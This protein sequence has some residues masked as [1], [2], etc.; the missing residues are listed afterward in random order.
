MLVSV[1]KKFALQLLLLFNHAYLRMGM[2]PVIFFYAVSRL[3]NKGTRFTCSLLLP[4]GRGLQ[5][6][7]GGFRRVLHIMILMS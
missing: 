6:L 2:Q 4:G 1:A 7:A 3:G 5:L